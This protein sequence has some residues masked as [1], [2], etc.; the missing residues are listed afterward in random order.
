M[1]NFNQ[2]RY[3]FNNL[4]PLDSMKALFT[5]L[6]LLVSV[7]GFSQ[8]TT[9]IYVINKTNRLVAIQSDSYAFIYR[10]LKS[11]KQIRS[12]NFETKA[13]LLTFFKL[14]QKAL[15]KD[16]STITS[17]YNV[18]RNRLSKNVVRIQDKKDG[19]VLLSYTTLDHM[20]SALEREE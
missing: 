19:Y 9:D 11:L 12:F 10:D 16:Q 8:D 18:S 2:W 14:C 7:F 3:S 1:L 4:I 13:D 20:R 6:F 15:D 5:S 17:D